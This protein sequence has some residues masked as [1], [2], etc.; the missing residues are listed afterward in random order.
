MIF[1]SKI[2]N[3]TKIHINEVIDIK[4]INTFVKLCL[5]MLHQKYDE[6]DFRQ[7]F[8][9]QNYFSAY[10]INKNNLIGFIVGNV[11]LDTLDIIN[12]VID[13]NF[14]N[15]SYASELLLTYLNEVRKLNIKEIFLEVRPT[16]INAIRLYEKFNFK[17]I[18]RRKHYYSN[19]EDALIY[20]NKTGD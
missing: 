8:S 10:L 5:D 9:S 3:K 7:F 4:H 2:N 17:Y 13:S 14:Q 18:H 16:N 11:N 20:L 12:I 1:D 6:S 19:G 15:K